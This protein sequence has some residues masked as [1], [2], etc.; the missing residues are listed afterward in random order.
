MDGWSLLYKSVEKDVEKKSDLLIVVTHWQLL[1]SGLKCLGLG[2]DV[3]HMR[4]I[5]R[6]IFCYRNR[7]AIYFFFPSEN[8]VRIG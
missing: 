6:M 2:D 4:Y 7:F 8:I 1:H 5:N 3:G